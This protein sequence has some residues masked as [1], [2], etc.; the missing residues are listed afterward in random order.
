MARHGSRAWL[1]RRF[2]R[3]WW[4]PPVG[5]S[6]TGPWSSGHTLFGVS[7][8]YRT[9]GDAAE[10]AEST[11]ADV[12]FH[13][14]GLDISAPCDDFLQRLDLDRLDEMR[15]ESCRERAL[16]VLLL[17]VPRQRDDQRPCAFGLST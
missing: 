2:L 8:V 10:D 4:A 6:L 11:A 3:R 17:S 5:R 1:R 7:L 15:I 14:A 9:W 13:Y 16:P 12:S